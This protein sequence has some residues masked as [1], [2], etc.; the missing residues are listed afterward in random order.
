MSVPMYEIAVI[1][2][3]GMIGAAAARHLVEAGRRIV[4]VAAPVV[5]VA[6]RRDASTASRTSVGGINGT[7]RRPIN[8]DVVVPVVVRSSSPACLSRTRVRPTDER[9]TTGTRPI[10]TRAFP[11]KKL[12]LNLIPFYRINI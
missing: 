10:G 5:T 4:V 1:G 3:G 12:K 7:L 8:A 9:T 6:T 11:L 2:G